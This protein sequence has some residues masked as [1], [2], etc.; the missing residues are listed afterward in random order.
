VTDLATIAAA[1]VVVRMGEVAV[2]G[3]AGDVLVCMGLGSCV[4][5]AVVARRV[6]A[7][8]LAHVMLPS[9]GGRNGDAW[10]GK[11][12]D[13][14]VPTL[15]N[16]LRM[17]GVHAASVDAYVVGGAQMFPTSVGMDVGARNEAAVRAALQAAGVLIRGVATAG[18][19]G[20]TLRLDV[21]TGTVTVREAGAQEVTLG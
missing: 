5:L 6:R 16:R 20:R 13:H 8:A 1:E 12:A 15:L 18:S 21:A 3:T 14:A 2:S 10:P 11:Y 19:T 17:F 4:G 9:S 7:A